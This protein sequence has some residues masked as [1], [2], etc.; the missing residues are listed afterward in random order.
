MKYKYTKEK[1]EC[2]VKES[3]SL[4]EVMRK[5]GMKLSGGNHSHLS[6]VIKK[7]DIDTKHFLGQAST[8]GRSFAKKHW[9]DI[10]VSRKKDTRTAAHYLR[11][12]LIESGRN[13]KCSSCGLRNIWNNKEITLE[14]HHKDG[15]WL[16]NSPE[17]LE[18]LCP[19]CHSQETITE[20]LKK[21]KRKNHKSNVRV[22]K[23]RIRKCIDCDCQVSQKAK[24]CKSCTGKLKPTKIDWPT[25][26]QL[27]QMLKTESYCSLARKL[28]V[29]DNAIRKKLKNMAR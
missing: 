5:L 11:R 4:R 1:L 13:Y 8:K 24:R 7:Y 16:N 22:R 28:K 17:N 20:K 15:D 2:V 14:I 27:K 25:N 10:L 19:N 3:I 26:E 29:S 21:E 23:V 18:F 9:S 12:A 6:K